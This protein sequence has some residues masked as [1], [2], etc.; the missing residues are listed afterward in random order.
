L[1]RKQRKVKNVRVLSIGNSFSVDAQTY[2]NRIFESAGEK[3]YLGNLY[4]GGCPLS[5]HMAN[6]ESGDEAYNYYVNTVDVGFSDIKTALADGKWDYITLQQASGMSGL[7]ESYEPYI[8]KIAEYVKA[9]QPEA[10]ILIHET[11][12]YETGSTHAHFAF[13]ENKRELM[14]KKI[15]ACYQR[16]AEILKAKMI[17]VGEAVRLLRSTDAFNPQKGGEALSRD[18]FHLSLVA[19]R[20]LAGL[21]WYE[22]LTGNSAENV[23]YRPARN[24][25]AGT[26]AKTGKTLSV[27]LEKDY[28]TDEKI[29]I[30]KEYAHKA[31]LEYYR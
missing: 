19:G 5:K 13:Y 18:G 29:C 25:F 28:P 31:V 7:W 3:V 6:I 15:Y 20:Y 22:C 14:E 24:R 23:E 11:W 27:P 16:A 8:E 9:Y 12:A 4:I 21:V 10:E 17:P 26:D 2:L 1:S 30:L